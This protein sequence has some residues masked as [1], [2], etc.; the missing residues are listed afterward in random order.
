MT[1]TASVRPEGA[2]ARAAA[3]RAGVE[4]MVLES[5]LLAEAREGENK[6][7]AGLPLI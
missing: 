1:T 3:R 4:R 7:P 6:P 2:H 5:A